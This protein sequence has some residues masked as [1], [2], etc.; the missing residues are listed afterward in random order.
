MLNQCLLLFISLILVNIVK[1]R[2]ASLSP[3][4]GKHLRCILTEVSPLQDT[5]D[6]F[7]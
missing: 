2:G 1:S 7:C 3:L 6:F 4:N 5:L